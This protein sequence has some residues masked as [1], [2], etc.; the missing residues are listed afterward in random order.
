[1]CE[2]TKQHF[3]NSIFTH[4]CRSFPNKKIIFTFLFVSKDEYSRAIVKY[5]L[6][7]LR[8]QRS[9][10]NVYPTNPKLTVSNFSHAFWWILKFQIILPTFRSNRYS[11]TAVTLYRTLSSLNYSRWE[12]EMNFKMYKTAI[13]YLYRL[14]NQ[15]DANAKI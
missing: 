15:R 10:S 14:R 3:I 8:A 12:A 4:T 2:F 9:S 13:F 11:F 6:H 5:A 1:M 7:S